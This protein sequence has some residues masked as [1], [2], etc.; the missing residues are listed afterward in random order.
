MET[1]ANAPGGGRQSVTVRLVGGSV[2]LIEIGGVRLLT[3]R[4]RRPWP[5]RRQYPQPG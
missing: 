2:A 4:S 5:D 3:D 1:T